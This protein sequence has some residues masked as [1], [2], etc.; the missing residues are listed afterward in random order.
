MNAVVAYFDTTAQTV[1]VHPKESSRTL[2][3]LTKVK[4]IGQARAALKRRGWVMD[5]ET[6]TYPYGLTLTGKASD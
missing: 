2:A 4:S 6:D 3:T 5:A 1:T